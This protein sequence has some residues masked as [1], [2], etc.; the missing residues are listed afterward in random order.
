MKNYTY[1][2]NLIDKKELKKILAWCFNNYTSTQACFLADQLKY[3]GFQYA[4]SSGISI[5]IEDLKVPFIK[6]NLL[7][8]A[9]EEIQNTGKI[10]TKGK[11]TETERFQKLIDTWDMVS[12]SL[13]TQIIYF[14]ENHDPLNSVYIMAFSGARGN[15]SQVR[16]LIGMRGLM[17][18]PSG[19]IMK[20]PIKKNF[21]EGLAVTDYLISGYGARKGIV[22]TALKTANSG[23]LTRRLIDV[24]Q[25]ILIREK[26]CLTNHS[27]LIFISDKPNKILG[28]V[29]NKRVFCQKTKTIIAEK[30]TVISASL[31]KLFYDSGIDKIYIRSPFTCKLYRAVCQRCYGW[32]LSTEN[33]VEIGEAVGILAGQSIG[34]PGTQL[35]MRTFHTGG[36][37]TS[38]T[39]QSIINPL[40]GIIK[41]NNALKTVPLRTNRGEDVLITKVSGFAIII[42]DDK[43]KD[44]VKINLLKNTILFPQNNQYILRNSVI[45][46]IINFNKQ[47]KLELKPIE[48]SQ[49]GEIFIPT[50]KHKKDALESTRYIWFLEGYLYYSPK[51]SFVNFYPDYKLNKS[52]S[53]FRTKIIT[54]YN[55]YILLTNNSNNLNNQQIKLQHHKYILPN[56]KIISLSRSLDFKNGLLKIKQSNYFIKIQKENVNNYLETGQSGLLGYLVTN[57]FQALTGGT[58]Y[59][60]YNKLTQN[61]NESKPYLYCNSSKNFRKYQSII[62]YRTSIWLSEES[63]LLNC[64]SKMV[65]IKSSKIISKGTQLVPNL[66]SKTTGFV[67]IFKRKNITKTI[68]I[69]P[70][71]LYK[72]SINN[73]LRNKLFYPGEFIDSNTQITELSFCESL[74]KKTS[75]SLLIRPVYLYE[76]PYCTNQFG[77][78]KSR[79]NSSY[80]INS[81]SRIL[82]LYKPNQVIKSFRDIRLFANALYLRHKAYLLDKKKIKIQLKNNLQKNR[83]EFSINEILY[84]KDYILSD[85]K[86]KKIQS[87]FLIQPDQFINQ[88]SILGYLEVI[89]SQALDIVQLKIK[90][91]NT[92]Q[93]LLI[94]NNHCSI[95]PKSKA[96][97]KKINDYIFVKEDLTKTGKILFENQSSF[98]IQKG[99]LYFFP[100]CSNES[101]NSKKNLQYKIIKPSKLKTHFSR[102]HNVFLNYQNNKKIFT[103]KNQLLSKTNFKAEFSKLFIKKNGKFYSCLIPQFIK[104]FTVC[105]KAQKTKLEK[106]LKPQILIKSDN[107][108]KINR[109][110]LFKNSTRYKNKFKESN[111][112]GYNLTLVKFLEQP[113]SKIKNSIGLYAIT[114]DF[115]T[116]DINSIFCENGEFIEAGKILGLLQIENE[117]TG[118]IIQ[119]LPRIERILEARKNSLITNQTP[120]SKKL[121]LL[122]QKPNLDVSF[123]FRTLGTPI[124]EADTINPHNLLK[125]YFNYYGLIKRFSC[126]YTKKFKLNRLLY[127]YEGAFKSFKKVQ[128]FILNSIQSVYQSQGVAINNKH[129]ELIIKQMTTKV[130][131]TYEGDTPLLRRE[132]IDL[133]HIKYM[134]EI[135]NIENKKIAY[136]IPLLLGITKAALRNPSFISAASFQETTGTLIKAAIEGRTDWLRGLK[137]NIITGQTI[138]AGTGFQNYQNNFKGIY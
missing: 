63:Y 13:K 120:I 82:Y 107:L 83:V 98:I 34:E 110:L 81:F 91:Q 105:H 59:Y 31:I 27:L 19:Q 134:N 71:F 52:N 26:D 132:I 133:Y 60:D 97:N 57:A 51:N 5:S 72:K 24:A 118:D 47:V 10:Y 22:D 84:L 7:S 106:I 130:L 39:R 92:K 23:Y 46:E 37:F 53:I 126:D 70:G 58:L 76:I 42:P 69:K 136:F 6:K 121:G 18:D 43:T 103:E 68:T 127:N 119:G 137:E 55:G 61:Y 65:T 2:N 1:Q 48:A 67:Q 14:F 49:S 87:C 38:K 44:L 114:D 138:P 28:R 104:K 123:D 20:L 77:N 29:L 66:L 125:V 80:V 117:I 56:S 129:L 108:K 16:Q 15:L 111:Y 95:I 50:V 90:E 113:F 94:S 99:Q 115:F 8:K 54:H 89:N 17:A 102:N 122:I 116:K 33:L 4:S 32:D 100:N 64:S 112:L 62:Q 25:D 3:L 96:P 74:F 131:I 128:V 36:V 135:L 79:S 78:F 86:Y 9:N 45:G 30:N 75:K 93:I 73:K 101:L 88:Y 109:T 41:Y 11:I 35:T 40:T 124:K 12:E 85:L 21:R